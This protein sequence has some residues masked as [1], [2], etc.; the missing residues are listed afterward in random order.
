MVRR[1]FM[2]W[3]FV[4]IVLLPG[5]VHAQSAAVTYLPPEQV[6]ADF[7]KLIDRPRGD[8]EPAFGSE[9]MDD[10]TI[11]SGIILSEPEELVTI[12]I[13]RQTSRTGRLPVV[14]CLHGTAGSRNDFDEILPRLARRG[15][16]AV[17][18]DARYHGERVLGGADGAAQYNEAIIAAWRSKPPEKQAHPY[19]YDT[20]Y[21]LWR[22]V[23][24]LVTLPDVDPDRIGAM[25]VSMGGMEVLLAAAVDPRIKVSI[26]M[27]A[28]QSLGWS[29]AN[30]RWQS[31]VS[32]ILAPHAIAAYDMGKTIIDPEVARALWNKVV[33][34]ALDEFDVPSLIRLFAPRPL[35]V[36]NSELDDTCPLPGAQLAFDQATTAY[37]KAGA[38]DHLR[39]YVA[40]GL[41]HQ[42]TA[43]E[44]DMADEW[45]DRW[46]MP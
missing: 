26:P 20:A 11:R 38:A 3:L 37:A 44:I 1:Q 14:I 4:L 39:I 27:I 35:L 28:V 32:T 12:T 29:L 30:D 40:P 8:L 24:Y 43:D 33:P 21:D 19:L 15:Y 6:R 18:F 41:Q 36:V 22:T 23:D 46:L 25:G 10:L 13:V 45:L 31:R 7:L 34:G 2:P 9:Q 42:V 17:A 16:V 5:M